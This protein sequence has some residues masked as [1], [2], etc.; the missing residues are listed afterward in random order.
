MKE[1]LSHALSQNLFLRWQIDSPDSQQG[2]TKF[3]QEFGEEF[4]KDS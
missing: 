4:S 1:V 2:G 3:E